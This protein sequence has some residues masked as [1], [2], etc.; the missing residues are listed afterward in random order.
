MSQDAEP[1]LP[2]E[3][4]DVP[5][6]FRHLPAPIHPDE[7]IETQAVSPPPDPTM[8]RDIETDRALLWS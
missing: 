8:G 7:T 2:A 3:Q 4:R 5:E 1:R 6:R